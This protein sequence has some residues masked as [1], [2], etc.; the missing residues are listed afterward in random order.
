MKKIAI[1]LALFLVVF[2]VQVKSSEASFTCQLYVYSDSTCS[3]A[4]TQVGIATSSE[5][6]DSFGCTSNGEEYNTKSCSENLP[7]D[8]PLNCPCGFNNT[9]P[10]NEFSQSVACGSSM[11]AGKCGGSGWQKNCGSNEKIHLNCDSGG[12]ANVTC[13]V[14]ASCDSGGSGGGV[15]SPTKIVSPTVTLT[16]S[17]LPTSTPAPTITAP[18]NC[19][20]KSQG[21]ANCLD[22]TNE[23]DF[24]FW[25]C[26]FLSNTYCTD[27]SLTTHILSGLAYTG[28][29]ASFSLETKVDLVDFEI[30]RRNFVT[31]NLIPSL[32]SPSPSI[33]ASATT[34]TMVPTTAPT[35]TLIKTPTNSP[36]VPTYTPTPTINITPVVI[37]TT[38]ICP[39]GGKFSNGKCWYMDYVEQSC[40]EVCNIKGLACQSGYW[41]DDSNCSAGKMFGTCSSCSS[42]FKSEFTPARMNNECYYN[43]SST[44][45]QNCDAAPGNGSETG[46][47]CACVP[48]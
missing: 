34:P 36:P 37:P 44:I 22:G 5:T 12:G 17:P 35:I 7:P 19:A 15:P 1:F 47:I 40:T 9:F 10:G 42:I 21:D 32:T 30:W 20:Q 33:T 29:F 43:P 13:A 11:N 16:P 45:G 6:N 4:G 38:I 41:N 39:V 3:G 28:K 27:I 46:R 31:L 8:P 18:V 14:D 48:K 25:Q 23:E 2:F 26:E 24:R